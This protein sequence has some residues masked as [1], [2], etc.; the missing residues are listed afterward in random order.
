LDWV[1]SGVENELTRWLIAASKERYAS[2]KALDVFATSMRDFDDVAL[3]LT[4][5]R[6]G[7]ESDRD[8]WGQRLT[9]LKKADFLVDDRSALNSLGN[10]VLDAWRQFGLT[11]E[12]QAEISRH[13][14]VIN[15]ALKLEA[16][17]YIAMLNYWSELRGRYDPV[18][19]I[20]N[21]DSLFALNFLDKSREGFAPGLHVGK[22]T[23]QV[24]EIELGLSSF[25]ESLSDNPAAVEGAKRLERT[26]SGKIPRARHRATFAIAM[27][28]YLT[29][30]EFYK[31]VIEKFGFPQKPRNW[32]GLDSDEAKR[33]G[34]V[35]KHYLEN[36]S[37]SEVSEAPPT[38]GI[39][40]IKKEAKPEDTVLKLPTVDYSAVLKGVPKPHKKAKPKKI[41]GS[42]PKTKIDYVAKAKRD[43]QVGDLGEE[44]ALN[45]ERWRL[46]DLPDLCKKIVHVAT[47]DDGA[48]FDILSFNEDGSERHV[49]VKTTTGPLSSDFFISEPEV[50]AAKAYAESYVILRV[51]KV[52][53]SPICCE[54]PYPFDDHV[55]LSPT[56]YVASFKDESA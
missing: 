28:L 20:D 23:T 41:S 53:S 16:T 42:K 9:D 17:N 30:G 47:E 49:E 12:K 44:F 6:D 26:C 39:A 8:R 55:M 3:D 34:L 46:R 24:V 38:G 1:G 18:L 5:I 25:A 36:G 33:L 50:Q 45:Y 31:T 14:V 2:E 22:V 48:G 54:I 7:K 27:E 40:K 19:L 56:S 11:S 10:N 29:N 35:L 37:V 4:I 32:T 21:W 51:A 13:V 15:E 52:T 43:K